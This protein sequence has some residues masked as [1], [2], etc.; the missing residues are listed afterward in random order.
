[1]KDKKGIIFALDGAIA[2]TIVLI[3]LIN[4]TY[5]FTTTSQESLSQTQVL[6]RGHDVMAMFDEFNELDNAFK[7]VV[8]GATEIEKEAPN[9]LNVTKYLPKGYNMTVYLKDVVKNNCVSGCTLDGSGT[10]VDTDSL[11]IGGDYYIQVNAKLLT[12]GDPDASFTIE[13]G[14]PP[15]GYAVTTPC[16]AGVTCTLTTLFP[17]ADLQTGINTID[18]IHD[19]S[20][21]FQ[22]YW[23][24]LLDHPDYTLYTEEVPP[25]GRFIGSGERWFASFD[26]NGHFSG[27][28]KAGFKVWLE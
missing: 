23:I 19:G 14:S 28:H 16:E 3:M 18:F 21:D 2:V 4:T 5:Y 26:D 17:V 27:M 9:G 7:A 6:K 12:A 1:M 10:S 15:V 8:D 22:I 24:K 20:N 25:S 11:S 13:F